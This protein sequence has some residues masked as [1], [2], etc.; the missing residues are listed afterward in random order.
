MWEDTIQQPGV[1]QL[2]YIFCK[3]LKKKF[4][5]FNPI[6]MEGIFKNKIT[7]DN[8]SIVS[9]FSGFYNQYL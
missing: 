5:S 7:S 8:Y 6:G 2:F 3:N 4:I 9:V 1:S